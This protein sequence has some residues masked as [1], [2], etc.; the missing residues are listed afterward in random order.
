MASASKN[1]YNEDSDEEAMATAVRT[2]LAGIIRRR[3]ERKRRA[4]SLENA[5]KYRKRRGGKVGRRWKQRH[6]GPI[7]PEMFAWWRLIH[8][9]DVTDIRSHN[10]KVIAYYFL[11]FIFPCRHTVLY[12][13]LCRR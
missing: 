9:P 7:R 5:P 4:D 11:L 6:K 13:L 8:A 10:G 1:C 12:I 2:I 3:G